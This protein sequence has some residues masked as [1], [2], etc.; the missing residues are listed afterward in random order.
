MEYQNEHY[1]LKILND[2]VILAMPRGPK[3]RSIC[4]ASHASVLKPN[5]EGV[6]WLL[7]D[8]ETPLVIM[9]RVKELFSEMTLSDEACIRSALQQQNFFVLNMDQAS[10][11]SIWQGLNQEENRETLIEIEALLASL[12]QAGFSVNRPSKRINVLGLGDVGSTMALALQAYGKGVLDEIGIFDLDP[13]RMQRWEME[14]NQ[15]AEPLG[16]PLPKVIMLSEEDL[17]ECDI[18]AFT[19]SVGV[20]PLTVTQGDVRVVQY[21][22]NSQLVELYIKKAMAASFKGIFAIVSDPVDLLCRF[23]LSCSER[24]AQENSAW[25]ALSPEQ[26][27]GYGLGVMNGRAAYFCKAADRDYTDGRVFGPHGEGLI[28]ANS[29]KK[30]AY[31]DHFSKELTESTMT[32]NLKMRAIGYKPYVAPAVASGAISLIKTLSGEWHYSCVSF[33][34]LYYGCL[35]RRWQLFEEHEQLEMD[36]NLFNRVEE[37]FKEMEAQWLRL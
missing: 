14:L 20:P 36:E 9:T 2:F 30:D 10:G 22:G 26:I 11:K 23:A 5:D 1:Q 28:T 37:S 21:H 35:N 32:A 33:N 29:W 15:I 8:S 13:H 18:F 3:A 16:M 34:G 17:F 24:I 31:D 19:A 12:K 6:N 25:A 7:K 27:R 4:L